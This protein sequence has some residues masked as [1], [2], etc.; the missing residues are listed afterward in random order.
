MTQPPSR[1]HSIRSAL[2]FLGTILLQAGCAMP[3]DAGASSP[4]SPAPGIDHVHAFDRLKSLAGQYEVAAANAKPPVVEYRSIA[5]GS[6]LLEAWKWPSGAE[7]LT[8]FFLD[9]GK[10]RATHYCHSGV[11]S[12]M[13]MVTATRGELAFRITSATNLSSPAVAHN[14]GFSYRLDDDS[15]VLRTEEWTKEGKVSRSQ[16]TLVRRPRRAGNGA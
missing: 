9:N 13:E 14:S 10:L 1:R 3:R 15:R 4:M 12:T 7:E 6:A 11:Q 5:R 2:P 8:V 16:E